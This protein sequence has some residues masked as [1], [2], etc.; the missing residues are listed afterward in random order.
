MQANSSCEIEL[1]FSDKISKTFRFRRLHDDAVTQ[2]SED[3][4]KML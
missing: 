4:V 1:L 2:L 3:V